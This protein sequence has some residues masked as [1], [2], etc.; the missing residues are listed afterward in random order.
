MYSFRDLLHDKYR[1]S[2]KAKKDRRKAEE[3]KQIGT[4]VREKP[5]SDTL[6]RENKRRREEDKRLQCVLSDDESSYTSV[7]EYKKQMTQKKS[8]NPHASDNSASSSLEG[9]ESDA[10]SQSSHP[11][12][13]SQLSSLEATAVTNL[14]LLNYQKIRSAQT[15]LG[16]IMPYGATTNPYSLPVIVSDA[17]IIHFFDPYAHILTTNLMPPSP[18]N[19]L[20]VRLYQSRWNTNGTNPP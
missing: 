19:Y 16:P 10:E 11:L 20:G 5:S 17:P 7:R 18:N 12:P 3:F 13:P 15:A 2:T 8:H 4:A 6:S 14:S 1:S 9:D